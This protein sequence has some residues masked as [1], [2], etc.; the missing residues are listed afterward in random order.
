[1][2]KPADFLIGVVELFAVLIPGALLTAILL[3]WAIGDGQPDLTTAAATLGASTAVRWVS[4]LVSAYVLGHVLSALGGLVL[5]PLYDKV[6]RD[7]WL[8]RFNRRKHGRYELV[9][10]AAK[11]TA[12]EEWTTTFKAALDSKGQSDFNSFAWAQ[13]SV[14]AAGNE[15]A[16]EIERTQADSKFFRSFVLVLLVGL[17]HV[18][19]I[20]SL[21]LPSQRELE[22]LLA[23][24]L[25]GLST[26]RYLALRLSAITLAYEHYLQ[27]HVRP[28]NQR[29]ATP[30]GEVPGRS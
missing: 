24:G 12:H 19:A 1:M 26:W 4:F 20:G 2:P 14:L 5:D 6:Y 22:L 28:A 21:V 27:L 8:P 15:G 7:W 13:A 9:A 3:S 25:L 23:A 29:G 17:A 30:P 18:A 11:A 10:S 16:A